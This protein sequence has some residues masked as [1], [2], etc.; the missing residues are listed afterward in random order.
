M[1]PA[2]VEPFPVYRS[3]RLRIDSNERGFVIVLVVDERQLSVPR[4]RSTLIGFRV[5]F[6]PDPEHAPTQ[7]AAKARRESPSTS[8]IRTILVRGELETKSAGLES[9]AGF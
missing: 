9:G 1:N 5:V 3:E 7:T 8:P 4:R 2:Q 6:A